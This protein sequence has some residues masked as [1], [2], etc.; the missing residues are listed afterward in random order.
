[1]RKSL[2]TDPDNL[3]FEEEKQENVAKVSEKKVKV[4]V[5]KPKKSTIKRVSPQKS[6]PQKKK[7]KKQ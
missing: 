5:K 7:P 1:M 3:Y 2:Y 6:G 4:T